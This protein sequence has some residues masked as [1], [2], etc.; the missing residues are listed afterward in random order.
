MEMLHH[1]SRENEKWLVEL[2]RQLEVL[3]AKPTQPLI[4]RQHGLAFQQIR[5]EKDAMN[6]RGSPPIYHLQNG[7]NRYYKCCRCYCSIL[8]LLCNVVVVVI[9]PRERSR[10]I[11]WRPYISATI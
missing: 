8:F 10:T 2:R 6:Y 9:W 3:R 11:H 5:T 1:R 7:I 4:Y